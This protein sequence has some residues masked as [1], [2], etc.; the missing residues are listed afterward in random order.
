MSTDSSGVPVN[1]LAVEV[2]TRG[3]R[4]GLTVRGELD[5]ATAPTLGALVSALVD[6]SHDHVT[7]NASGVGF[8]DT[9]GVRVIVAALDRLGAIGGQLVISAASAAVTRIL[10]ITDVA[11]RVGVDAQQGDD[12]ASSPRQAGWRAPGPVTDMVRQVA[13]IPANREVIDAAFDLVVSLAAGAISGADGVS[14][15]LRRQGHL[16]TVAATDETVTDLDHHQ[17]DTGEGPCVAAARQGRSFQVDSAQTEQRWPAFIPHAVEQGITGIL[18]T[19]LTS[20][21]GP[22]GSINLY[23]RHERAFD[24]HDREL[25][26][27][28]A[29]T[30]STI[31]AMDGLGLTD[32]DIAHRL[33]HALRARETIA[34]AQGVLIGQEVI[35]ADE[36]YNRLRRHS[37]TTSQTILDHA[38]QIIETA[39]RDGNNV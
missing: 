13:A 31:V 34:Q 8:M 10:R 23:T 26:A 11:A 21:D 22:V 14:V 4:V 24:D 3:R 36:A 25:A 18:S 7:L 16:A 35:S 12:A 27:S 9:A 1:G 17:Y 2:I 33:Q 29:T 19:P 20:D 39:T 5:A 37:Q 6:Q 30:S 15:S 38:R 28:L 32:E